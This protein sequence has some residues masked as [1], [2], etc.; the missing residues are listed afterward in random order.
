[1]TTLFCCKLM[2]IHTSRQPQ[3]ICGQLGKKKS[4][5]YYLCFY[6]QYI[7]SKIFKIFLTEACVN[8]LINKVKLVVCELSD[9]QPHTYCAQTSHLSGL[10]K[11]N[12]KALCC[13]YEPIA[14][15][16]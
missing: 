16:Y 10:D 4:F 6:S 1:M 15:K 5:Y 2:N 9:V 14:P 7:F 8:I 12:E 11:T 13:D 3:V